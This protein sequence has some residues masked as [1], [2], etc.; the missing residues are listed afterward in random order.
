MIDREYSFIM[1][2]KIE[3][4]FTNES[5]IHFYNMDT[6]EE[7]FTI[8][9]EDLAVVQAAYNCITALWHTYDVEDEENEINEQRRDQYTQSQNSSA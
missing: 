9:P 7:L 2:N 6:G 8:D 4:S 5:P 1:G 3:V